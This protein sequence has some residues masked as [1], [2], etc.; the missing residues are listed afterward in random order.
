M[1]PTRPAPRPALPL[2]PWTT[3]RCPQAGACPYTP[4]GGEDC[5]PA[6]AGREASP[7]GRVT[8]RRSPPPAPPSAWDHRPPH[9]TVVAPPRG[10]S[11]A[12]RPGATARRE[13]ET[14]AE[15]EAAAR[16]AA[17]TRAE[18]EAVARAAAETRAEREATARE[19]EAAARQEAE[20]QVAALRA[21]LRELEDGRP[22]DGP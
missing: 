6:P 4:L 21:R 1:D 20:A 18:R 5:L 9:A 22:E 8:G 3:S 12:P 11:P 7:H 17:E 19:R 10:S 16:E 13:A 2:R 14:R 15:Q